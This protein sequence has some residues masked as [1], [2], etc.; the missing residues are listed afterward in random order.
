MNFEKV[1]LYGLNKRG[2]I[3]KMKIEDFTELINMTDISAPAVLKQKLKLNGKI[4]KEMSSE[5][6]ENDCKII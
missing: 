3:S 5:E 1:I 6:F 2:M 4:I